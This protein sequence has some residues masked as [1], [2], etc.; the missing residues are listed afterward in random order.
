MNTDKLKGIFVEALE[1]TASQVTNDLTYNSIPEWDSIAHMTLIAEIED[2]FDIMLD[3]D[4]VLDMSS[5][6]KAIEILSKY[7]ISFE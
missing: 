7:D 4:D 5:F 3:T 2:Q 6:G 1:I